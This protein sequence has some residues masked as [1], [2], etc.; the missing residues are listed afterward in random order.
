MNNQLRIHA[1]V[2]PAR[3]AALRCVA[4]VALACGASAGAAGCW[5][6]IDLPTHSGSL[7]GQVVISGGV[8][9]AQVQVDQLD[10]KTGEVRFLVGEAVTDDT[11][12]FMLE[13]GTRNGIFRILAR[14]GV[15]E[16]LATGATIE[17]DDSDELVSLIWYQVLE[18][19]EGPVV[20]PIGQLVAVR[21]MERLPVL[22]NMTAAFQ[23]S[24]MS[25][26]GHFGN[27]DWGAVPFWPL[28]QRATSP[29]EPVRAALVHAALSVL[30]R[31]IAAEAQAG[32][33]EVNVFRLMQ[34]WT[35]DVRVGVFD[36]NDGD[37]RMEGS[38]LQL[39]YCPPIPPGCAATGADCNT[40]QCRQRCDLYSGTPRALL[41][42]A[43]LK[44]IAD[45]G[46]GGLN[47]TGLDLT[48]MLSIVRAVSDNKDPTLFEAPC[49]EQLDRGPPQV[50]FDAP[51]PGDAAF[52]RGTIQ[53]KA[54]AVDDLDP[55]P[56]TSL[57]GLVDLDQAPDNGV[58]LASID[59]ATLADGPQI[60]VARAVD[61]TGNTAMIQRALTVDN[62]PPAVTVDPT[63]FFVEGTTWWTATTAPVLAG[64][65]ADA[66]PV[67]I[68]AVVGG[69]LE[70]A[71][72]VSGTIWTIDLP[73][74][75]LDLGGTPVQI[76]AV[77]A[78]G[79]Q[80][81]ELRWLR[82]DVAPPGLGF[83]TSTVSDE[84]DEV[85]GFAA[86]HSPEHVHLGMPVELS[87]AAAC[88]RLTKFSY[89]LGSTSP[90]YARE[91]PGPNPIR[92]QLITDDPGVGITAGST[93]YRVGLRLGVMQTH[94]VLDWTSAGNGIP[95]GTGVTRFPVGIFSDVVAGL[96]TTAGIYDVELRATDRLGRTTTVSRCFDL[97]LRAPPLKLEA[98]SASTPTKVHAY[99]LDSLRLHPTAQFTQI[100][101]RLLNDDATGASL[102]DQDIFNGTTATV[103]LT[104]TVTRPYSV[105]VAQS[106]VLDNAPTQVTPPSCGLCEDADGVAPYDSPDPAVSIEM[107][108]LPFPVKVFE[109][110]GGVPTT[111]IPCLAPCPSS[112]TVFKFAI[113]PRP[114]GGQPAR[115]F[116]VMTMI[117]QV[118]ALWPRDGQEHPAFPPFEDA[119]ITWTDGA[120]ATTT[121]DL[122]GIVDRSYHAERTGC[123]KR[124]TGPTGT[125]LQVGT[126]VPYQAL[127][128]ATLTFSGPT[129]T[130]YE[131]AATASQPPAFAKEN[132]RDA[133]LGWTTSE[134]P[135]PRSEVF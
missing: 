56:D 99:A 26:H 118:S 23:E 31:D 95:L 35:E 3:T 19:R 82:P 132:L 67:S 115:A 103:Y 66:A 29:T 86:D 121:T 111:E 76:V 41:A 92:Y 40:G 119:A 79:N 114:S 50:R 59:T 16:D 85:I 38:G 43:I 120:G 11:G 46:P 20:T 63:G 129:R 69:A 45:R 112:G 83:D 52:V 133:N 22:G 49:V 113:P 90:E 88:P 71:G 12:T 30:A 122:T 32:P 68:K 127:R 28:A 101:A 44:V 4:L 37:S 97:Q 21:T 105:M 2:E 93:E 80:R 128:S 53:I 17:L 70:V 24:R 36:G 102:I 126:L 124:M 51:T 107:T 125:C 34:R 130:R 62:T 48:N 96:A 13:T 8:R 94:W 117:G 64:T 78:A 54:V 87:T 55:S 57:L 6:D 135:L 73:A 106:F 75:S 131:T 58:A 61:L 10:L 60:V 5:N 25:L 72:V 81:H 15:Y 77:D 7:H 47:Q 18:R 74:G 109:L 1:V 98:T 91:L 89:L 33:Q 14:G 116:R 42:G 134:G 123:V 100:A 65:V 108:A 27:V 110:T 39:G 84:E 9:G 104:V